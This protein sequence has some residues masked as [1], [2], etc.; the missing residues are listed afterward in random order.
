V[1]EWDRAWDRA[2][3]ADDPPPAALPRSQQP[4]LEW[5]TGFWPTV[6]LH[7]TLTPDTYTPGLPPARRPGAAGRDAGPP[8]NPAPALARQRPRNAPGPR[9]P[10]PPA[11]ST[12]A[13]L[14]IRDPRRY[15]LP[16]RQSPRP[17]HRR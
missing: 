4:N 17:A 11:G 10:H 6:H 13:G 1:A 5:L 16:A 2:A 8:H 9:R 7:I 3:R 15:T 12:R 14:P